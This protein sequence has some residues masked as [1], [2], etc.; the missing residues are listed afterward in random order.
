MKTKGIRSFLVIFQFA[1]SIFLIIFTL[2]VYQQIQFMQEKNLGLDKEQY[3]HAS[4]H[5]PIG[6]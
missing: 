3:S 6:K 2:V 5:R 4:K 1:L